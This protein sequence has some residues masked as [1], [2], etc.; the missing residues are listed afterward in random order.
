MSYLNKEQLTPTEPKTIDEIAMSEV[1]NYI[2][3]VEGS[4]ERTASDNQIQQ[5][6][7]NQNPQKPQAAPPASLSGSN[8][9]REQKKIV[10]PVDESLVRFGLASKPS[11]GVKWLAEWC[12]M[13]IK[14]YPG[15]VFY[16]PTQTYD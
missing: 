3:K 14:K 13:M 15:R 2:E 10:L 4:T 9:Q 8:Q 11:S 6:Q 1:D 7:V 12:V 5:P 16:S